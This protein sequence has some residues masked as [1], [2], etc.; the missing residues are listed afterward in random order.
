MVLAD[1]A[2]HFEY[3]KVIKCDF[4]PGSFERSIDLVEERM[5]PLNFFDSYW[6]AGSQ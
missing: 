6:W 5:P 3:G 4:K 1:A 2:V